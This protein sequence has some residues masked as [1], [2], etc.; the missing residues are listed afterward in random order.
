VQ[1][2]ALS[3]VAAVLVL[4]VIAVLVPVRL[5]LKIK[6]QGEVGKTWAIAGGAELSLVTVSIAIAQGLDGVLQVHVYRW[7]VLHV[8]PFGR[9]LSGSI[10]ARRMARDELREK[11]NELRNR[12]DRRFGLRAALRFVFS[13]RRWVVLE[14]LHANLVYSTHDVALT[15][16]LLGQLYTIAGLLAPWGQLRVEARWIDVASADANLD[17]VVRLYPVRVALDVLMFAIRNIK[18][19]QREQPMASPAQP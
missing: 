8:T 15:G 3:F 1:W 6:G 18:L 10:Q 16:M 7:R 14:K 12:V 17:V 19:R 9:F 11:F 13:Q 5:R 2:I 4:A